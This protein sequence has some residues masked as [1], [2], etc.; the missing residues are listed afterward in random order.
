MPARLNVIM[1]E[2]APSAGAAR[3][4]AEAVVGELIGLSGIDLTLIE[5]LDR[6]SDS[7][8][9]KLTLDGI[10]GD[11]CVLDWQSPESVVKS[12][13][14]RGFHGRRAAHP[15]DQDAVHTAS[16]I[17]ASVS[18]PPPT[19]STRRIYAFELSRF[20][21]AKGL[22]AAL[23]S[24][25]A[26]REVRT[27]SLTPASMTAAPANSVSSKSI[28]SARAVTTDTSPDGKPA[29]PDELGSP[30][31]HS[32]STI[33][34][35]PS[36]SSTAVAPHPGNADAGNADAGNAQA[37]NAHA[38]IPPTVGEHNLSESSG[39]DLEALVDQLDEFDR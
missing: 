17:H 6:I 30:R 5:S 34:T 14:D 19:V 37:G 1:I 22:C 35:S 13:N 21:D 9:D 18:D 31:I 16:N 11:V 39:I 26:T 23:S 28:T 2:S 25:R 15:H 24:L 32:V 36:G 12:L 10:T 8:T 3:R 27:F 33:E 29:T 20:P 7:S 4:M 38:G